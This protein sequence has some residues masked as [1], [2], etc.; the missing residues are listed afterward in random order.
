MYKALNGAIVA[1]GLA[2]AA[3]AM[4]GPANADHVAIHVGIHNVGYQD[5]Y[6]DHGHQWHQWRNQ[7]EMREYRSTP[8]NRYNDYRHD[9]G[10]Q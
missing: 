8:G 10:H 4:S 9:R 5:G 2:G 3:L 1:L 6:Y 7:R